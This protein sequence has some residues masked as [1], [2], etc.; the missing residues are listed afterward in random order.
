MLLGLK[1]INDAK[2]GP[3]GGGFSR[4][5]RTEYRPGRFSQPLASRHNHPRSSNP[6]RS[7]SCPQPK[8]AAYGLEPALTA[9]SASTR[10]CFHIP[11]AARTGSIPGSR[12]L[13][14]RTHSCYKPRV[15][16]ADLV[17]GSDPDQDQAEHWQRAIC[18]LPLRSP[19]EIPMKGSRH[20]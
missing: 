19:V 18:I 11:A 4:Q 9:A 14:V 1:R 10:S 16:V 8:S 15:G 12:T 5:S 3:K 13:L 7:S 6:P 17:L 2:D 20:C